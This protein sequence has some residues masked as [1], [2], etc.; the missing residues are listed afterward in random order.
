M[1][2]TKQ[3]RFKEALV[4]CHRHLGLIRK[5]RKI[6]EIRIKLGGRGKILTPSFFEGEQKMA[7]CLLVDDSHSTHA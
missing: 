7:A 3:D 2:Q 5:T 4:N 1:L 6:Q